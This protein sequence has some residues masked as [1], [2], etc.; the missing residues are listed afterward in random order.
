MELWNALETA[1]E[2]RDW[3]TATKL[4]Q[5]YVDEWPSVRDLVLVFAGEGAE[6][7]AKEID[8]VLTS[9]V[10]GL[11]KRPVDVGALEEVMGRARVFVRGD[12]SA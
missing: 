3:A 2:Q 11:E 7:W 5:M 4:A 8:D 1:V 10:A 6:M 9:L 12:T